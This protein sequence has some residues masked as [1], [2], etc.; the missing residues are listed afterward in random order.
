M[1]SLLYS[2]QVDTYSVW[3]NTKKMFDI[4]AAEAE[5]ALKQKQWPKTKNKKTSMI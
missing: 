5:S 2:S 1:A 3:V 4:K